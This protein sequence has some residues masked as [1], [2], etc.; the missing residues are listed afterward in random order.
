MSS[1]NDG[2]VQKTGYVSDV[3]QDRIYF[4]ALLGSP[5][6]FTVSIG[7]IRA[8]NPVWENKPEG[9]IGLYH[10]S[11]E[12]SAQSSGEVWVITSSSSFVII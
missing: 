10:G 4:T 1:A 7:G 5:A 8:A 3:M 9:G 11:V 12:F 6:D 2:T